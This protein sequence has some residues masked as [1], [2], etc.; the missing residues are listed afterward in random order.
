MDA[1]TYR[2]KV[3]D[4]LFFSALAL[5]SIALH[6]F[7]L[8]GFNLD[9]RPLERHA[10]RRLIRVDFVKRAKPRLAQT[11]RFR[12]SPLP[13]RTVPERPMMK[14]NLP[15]APT[16]ILEED[17]EEA[18]DAFSRFLEDLE[19]VER[20]SDFEFE[21]DSYDILAGGVPVASPDESPAQGVPG[22]PEDMLDPRVQ[23]IV[24]SYPP[25]SIE[26]KYSYVLYP[27]IK[28]EKKDYQKGWTSVY[29]EVAI[30]SRGGIE[31]IELLRPREPNELERTFVDAV[32]ET[33]HTWRFDRKRAE[34][35]VDVRFYV[36]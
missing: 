20:M 28:I 35:H 33:I 15:L 1:L 36:E 25:T 24:N 8:F 5:I 32:L 22:V 19:D 34:I 2:V 31:E 26:R 13:E 30:D 17:V 16:P 7:L 29:F 4:V 23:M 6:A 3:K 11:P 14:K 9:F 12:P 21:G 18:P 27:D 10:G